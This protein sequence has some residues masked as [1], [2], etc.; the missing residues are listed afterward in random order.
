METKIKVFGIGFHKTGTTSLANALYTLGYYVTGFFGVYDPNIRT[1]VY[2]QAH[3]LADR[4]DGAQ[5]TPWPVIYK[6]LDC[7]YPGSKFILTIRPTDEWIASI[8][9]H[10]KSQRIPAHEWIYGV[11]TAAR[12]E[13]VYIRR[14]ENHNREVIDYFKDRPGDLLVMDITQGDGWEKLCPFLGVGIPPFRFPSQNTVGQRSIPLIYRGFRS[15]RSKLLE[16]NFT[17]KGN[18][19]NHGVSSTFLRDLLH[20]HYSTFET[21]WNDVQWI[22]E[23]QFNQENPNREGSIR[24]HL[25]RQVSEEYAC[26]WQLNGGTQPATAL[27]DASQDQTKEAVYQYW[28]STRLLLRQHAANLTDKNCNI[29][30]TNNGRYVWEVYMHLFDFGAQ[31]RALIHCILLNYQI[32]IKE[33]SILAFYH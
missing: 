32:M 8:V 14:Y 26:Y 31:Q 24:E 22:D 23:E 4:Y 30:I 25:I 5:D 6:E 13:D 7:W 33:P 20:Y 1:V 9:K 12:N 19:M 29:K 17:D 16:R 11:E 2:E 10:F 18:E 15:I 27:L 28:N 21:I 3:L